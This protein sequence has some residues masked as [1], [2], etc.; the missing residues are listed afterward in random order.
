MGFCTNSITEALLVR[1]DAD[2]NDDDRH[3]DADHDVGVL[4]RTLP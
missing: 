1:P 3:D 4:Y 2:N